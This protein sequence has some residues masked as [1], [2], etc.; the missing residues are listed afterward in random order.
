MTTPLLA[1]GLYLLIW[2][3]YAYSCWVAVRKTL[4]VG[5]MFWVIFICLASGGGSVLGIIFLAFTDWPVS[6]TRRYRR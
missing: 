3:A 6:G 1:G 4:L 5:F 2:L